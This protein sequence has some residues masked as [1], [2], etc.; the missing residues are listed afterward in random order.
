MG[1]RQPVYGTEFALKTATNLV[2]IMGC[3]QP[4]CG[5]EFC[6]IGR[7]NIENFWKNDYVAS[8]VNIVILA[9]CTF[10]AEDMH[11]A[12]IANFWSFMITF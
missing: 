5:T 11:L 3:R 1:C 7:G 2:K 12:N 4:V 10:N 9:F 8:D 6:C